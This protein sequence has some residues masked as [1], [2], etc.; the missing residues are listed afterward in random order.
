M[1]F[2]RQL[3][4][5]NLCIQFSLCDGIVI[6]VLTTQIRETYLSFY[7]SVISVLTA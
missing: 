4:C 3:R 1:I 2:G 7:V 5:A 6:S